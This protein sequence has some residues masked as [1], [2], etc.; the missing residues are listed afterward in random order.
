MRR[1]VPGLSRGEKSE[2]D[3]GP[4]MPRD[5]S[6]ENVL[7]LIVARHLDVVPE[8][9]AL[10]R[11]PTGKYNDT[12]FIEGGPMPPVLRIAPPDDRSRML[13]YEHHMMRPEP[14]LHGLLRE[15]TDVPVP[16]ILA[17]DFGHA[18]IDRDYLLMERLP[19]TPISHVGGL[20]QVAFDDLLR[21]VGRCLRQ[22]HGIT[23]DRDGYVGDHRPMEPQAD[24][25][26]AFH[27]M[28]H[29]HLDDIERCNGYDSIALRCRRG[30][31]RCGRQGHR[32]RTLPTRPPLRPYPAHRRDAR[33][34]STAPPF[35]PSHPAAGRT[36]WMMYR[37]MHGMMKNIQMPIL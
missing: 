10:R 27:V 30:G 14:G 23:G 3:G 20:T 13:S 35:P 25:P 24:W 26:S 22:V 21:E 28:W 33:A 29:S 11:S 32:R 1:V 18:A 15:R 2:A 36:Q 7:A 6:D 12:Y 4:E 9:L 16:R 37:A 34:R 17:H 19:G 8:G 5:H 31:G